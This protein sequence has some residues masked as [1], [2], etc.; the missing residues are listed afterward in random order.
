MMSRFLGLP[1]WGKAGV[2]AAALTFA[3]VAS[4]GSGDSDTPQILRTDTQGFLSGAPGSPNQNDKSTGKEDD[5]PTNTN[6][7]AAP[8]APVAEPTSTSTPISM[9]TTVATASAVPPTPIPPT[10]TPI[11]PTPIPPTATPIPPT[12][13]PPTATPIA[14][15]ATPIPPTP[16]PTAAPIPPTPIPPP[17]T[18]PPA[19]QPNA[20]ASG[21]TAGYSP[22][23]PPGDDVDCAGGSGNGPRYVQGPIQVTGSDPYRLDG[24]NDGIGCE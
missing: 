12:P 6:A 23:I 7:E 15:T 19:P 22:C 2:V 18:V 11:P 21:C 16:V 24:D 1:R 14:P 13:V 20:S 4:G 8:T 9:Q 17:P 3:I 5:T 10:A